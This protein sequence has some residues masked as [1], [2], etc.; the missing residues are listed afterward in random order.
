MRER[1]KVIVKNTPEI[2]ALL[3]QVKH[4]VKVTPIDLP[5]HLPEDIDSIS[6]YLHECGKLYVFPKIDEKR[7]KATVDFQ[8]DPKRLDID[9]IKEHLRLRWLNGGDLNI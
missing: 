5:D 3:W 1:P 2:C 9:T 7:Y 6:T 4:L 8:N